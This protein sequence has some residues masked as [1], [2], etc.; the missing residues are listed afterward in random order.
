MC[1]TKLTKFDKTAQ[2]R[3]FLHT[4][5]HTHTHTH[6]QF[7]AKLKTNRDDLFCNEFLTGQTHCAFGLFFVK[8]EKGEHNEI[9]GDDFNV[10]ADDVFC[11]RAKYADANVR[12]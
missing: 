10:G 6:R 1:V 7:I 11:R 12:Q 4:H 2:S 3:G 5:T 8:H 9:F